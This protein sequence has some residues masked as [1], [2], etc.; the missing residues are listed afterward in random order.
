[1]I[2]EGHEPFSQLAP[3][4]RFVVVR[5]FRESGIRMQDESVALQLAG[6]GVTVNTLL[7]GQIATARIA[8]LY[9]SMAAAAV[10]AGRLGRPE[11]MA[12]VA[13][14]CA[15]TA[16]GTSRAR[17]SRSTAASCAQSE[18]AGCLGLDLRCGGR[19]RT[20]SQEHEWLQRI[21]GRPAPSIV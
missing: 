7:T 9:G 4:P 6:D 1:M 8:G 13:L 5:Q 10:P 14:S 18:L 20:C 16:L 15:L 21:A 11:E 12:W 3:I 17:Q 2:G 19:L